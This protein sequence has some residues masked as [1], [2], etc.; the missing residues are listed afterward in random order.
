MKICHKAIFIATA[1]KTERSLDI[2]VYT[3]AA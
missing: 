2:R 3:V 1:V